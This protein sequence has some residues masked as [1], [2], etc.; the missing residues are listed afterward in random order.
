MKDRTREIQLD[1]TKHCSTSGWGIY[2]GTWPYNAEGRCLEGYSYWSSKALHFIQ[3][4][5]VSSTPL[6]T[7]EFP[8]WTVV[9]GHYPLLHQILLL[10]PLKHLKHDSTFCYEEVSSPQQKVLK[11]LRMINRDNLRTCN[12]FWIYVRT[13]TLITIF[14][15]LTGDAWMRN[16]MELLDRRETSQGVTV[17]T[18]FHTGLQKSIK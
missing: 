1:I 8:S 9:F 6:L 10:T 13:D 2:V 18:W 16:F 14:T 3:V 4:L 12:V 17:K 15:V 11:Y 5:V 7:A